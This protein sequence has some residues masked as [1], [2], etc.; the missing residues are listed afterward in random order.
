LVVQ[1]QRRKPLV[2]GQP[3]L[4]FFMG[5]AWMSNFMT[6]V[7]KVT[8][9]STATRITEGDVAVGLTGSITVD[10]AGNLIMMCSTYDPVAVTIVPRILIWDG[11][12]LKQIEG[13]YSNQ[14]IGG[15]LRAIG[16][17]I[18]YVYGVA[19]SKNLQGDPTILKASKLSP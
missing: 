1:T 6:G 12:T 10:S 13:D 4:Y 17:S 16:D 2:S 18:Y 9:S 7:F 15:A 5:T 3:Q 11:A 8:G 19:S 14:I